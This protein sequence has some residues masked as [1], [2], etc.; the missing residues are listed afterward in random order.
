MAMEDN[1]VT[2]AIHTYERAII[3]KN[4]LESNGIAVVLHNVNLIQPLVSAGVRVRIR[5][6]DLPEALRIIETLTFDVKNNGVGA[7]SLPS[8]VLVPVDFSKFTQQAVVFAFSAAKML[9]ASVVL[10]HTYYS[11]FY[12]GGFPVGDTILYDDSANE[13]YHSLIKKNEASMEL[14]INHIRTQ[15]AEGKLPDIQFIARYREGVPEEQILSYSRKYKP[16][17]VVMGTKGQNANNSSVL[18]GSVTA[19]VLDRSLM[20][21]FA[22]PEKT[23]FDRFDN[24]RNIGFLTH[25]DQRDLIAFDS[26]MNLLK[27]CHYKVYFIHLSDGSNHWDEIQLEG[28]KEYLR[29]RY[30]EMDSSYVLMNGRNVTETLNQFISDRHIDVLTIPSHKRNIFARL[31]NPGIARRMVFHSETPLFV[32]R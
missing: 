20:P 17:L 32:I 19:E 24:I 3:I 21:V 9:D 8:M 16:L 2:V 30:P 25:F 14:L 15:V 13:I 18:L 27:P 6:S 1:L 4:I 28:I 26:M 23:P 31:F 7:E 29:K 10:L 22:F 12:S 5:E 11:P